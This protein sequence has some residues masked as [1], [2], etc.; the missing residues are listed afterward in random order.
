MQTVRVRH[1]MEVGGLDK[2]PARVWA[3]RVQVDAETDC[4]L[5]SPPFRTAVYNALIHGDG[6]GL[7]VW[8][9]GGW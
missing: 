8:L 7:D 6:S 4:F 3:E 9:I 2:E 5:F 1:T